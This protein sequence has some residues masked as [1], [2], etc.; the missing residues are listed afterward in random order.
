[1]S[2][3]YT[4]KQMEL[5]GW[6]YCQTCWEVWLSVKPGL[7]ALTHGPFKAQLCP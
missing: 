7:G 4:V 3:G 5:Q 6:H 1:M 2:P